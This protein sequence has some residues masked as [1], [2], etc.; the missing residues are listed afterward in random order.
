MILIYFLLNSYTVPC[1]VM[2][3]VFRVQRCVLPLLRSVCNAW[4]CV[5]VRC[6]A[7]RCVVMRRGASRCLACF[8]VVLVWRCA[9][10]VFVGAALGGVPENVC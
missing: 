7:L 5:A 9:F 6:D 4:R 2:C 10:G 8:G 1:C 3:S